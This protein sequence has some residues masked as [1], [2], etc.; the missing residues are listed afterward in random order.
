LPGSP[1][2]TSTD[3]GYTGQR[4]LGMGLMD[5][6]ARFYSP[7]ITRFS[8]PDTIVPN[9]YDPQAWNRYSYALNNPIRYNDP[10]GHCVVCAAVILIAGAFIL[11]GSVDPGVVYE[12]D[13]PLLVADY[14]QQVISE[15][16]YNDLTGFSNVVDYAASL[17]PDCASCL[18][19]NVGA[20]TTGHD[21]LEV[22]LGE[23]GIRIFGASRD[24]LYE[25]TPHFGQVVM[26]QFFKTL[27]MRFKEEAVTKHFITGIMCN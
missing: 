6:K 25:D 11:S 1:F 10:S 17:N 3:L 19:R 15:D 27:A 8:Q 2:I 22:L 18:V 16:S 7:Y 24:R 14:Q 21:D 12:P 13:Y 23:L 20:V 26:I 5:Y 4:D 9:L